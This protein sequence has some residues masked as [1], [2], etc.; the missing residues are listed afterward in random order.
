MTAKR[1][2]VAIDPGMQGAI[3]I[4]HDDELVQLHDMPV[5]PDCPSCL[6]GSCNTKHKKSDKQ[7]ID[8]AKI[9]EIIGNC[10][11]SCPD[12]LV[13]VE[14]VWGARGDTPT[15]AFRL[16]SA[17]QA[18]LTACQ[19]LSVRIHPV[20]AI[21][22]KTALSLKKIPKEETTKYAAELFPKHSFYTPRG[23]CLD[24]RGDAA[25][26]GLFAINNLYD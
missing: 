18:I 12:V 25:L 11:H 26:I 20:A 6:T 13:V 1:I 16:G 8:S 17:Y 4:F 24:G 10:L 3:A 7:I 22:W 21:T 14:K 23:R 5:I 9:Y 2:T 15:T 19:C